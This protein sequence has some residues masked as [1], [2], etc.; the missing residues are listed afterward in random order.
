MKTKINIV[1]LLAGILFGVGLSLSQMINPQK[2]L[3]FLDVFGHWD[4][5]LAL[6]MGGALAVTIPAYYFILRDP[7]PMI[8]EKFYLPDNTAIDKQLVLGAALFGIGWGVAGYCPGPAVAAL[9]I[10]WQEAVPFLIALAVGGFASDR[11]LR[12]NKKNYD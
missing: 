3:A 9:S 8:A 12:I 4:P 1:A 7:A 2:V 6:V 5:S 11:A 10:N